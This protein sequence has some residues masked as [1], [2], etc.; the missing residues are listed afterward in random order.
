VLRAV[1]PLLLAAPAAAQNNLTL[2]PYAMITEQAFSATTTFKGIFG[3][4]AEPFWGAGAQLIL[5]NNIFIDVSASR[6]KKTGSRAVLLNGQVSRTNIPLEVTETPFEI[7]AGYRFRLRRHPRVV[8]FAGAGIGWYAYTQTT[9]C[10]SDNPNCVISSFVD[11]GEDVDTHHV[12]E[13][14]V[15][16]VEFRVH[17]WIALSVD[18][19][20]THIPGII[21]D[22]GF[23][24][25][26][27]ES[28]LGGV[29][30]RFKLIVG[31]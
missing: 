22:A 10:P 11:P 24:K 3:Q 26:A 6:F 1:L 28:D 30:G 19:Q 12:G 31:R 14:V 20:Y 23:S 13:L 27:G 5:R 16:G 15:G 17:R 21:G 8:P 29:A 18:A 9:K 7:A 2:R 25:D 4:S